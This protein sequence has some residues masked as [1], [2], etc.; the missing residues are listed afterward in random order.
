MLGARSSKPTVVKLQIKDK[1]VS[2]ELAQEQQLPSCH[3]SMQQRSL[4]PNAS[5][6]PSNIQLR[7]YTGER[8]RTVGNMSVEVLRNCQQKSL[9]L[10]VV[11][12]DGPQLYSEGTGYSRLFWTGD[13]FQLA[14]HACP[15]NSFCFLEGFFSTYRMPMCF[16]TIAEQFSQVLRALLFCHYLKLA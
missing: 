15:A 16:H 1:S 5:L 2:M 7:S 13:Q 4:F 14:V 6:K 3:S 12:Q 10:T 11:A 8:V 9:S